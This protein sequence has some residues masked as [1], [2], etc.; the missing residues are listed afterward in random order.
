MTKNVKYWRCFL[1]LYEYFLGNNSSYIGGEHDE[2]IG[3]FYCDCNLI[4]CL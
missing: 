3:S 2:D 1:R 4:G